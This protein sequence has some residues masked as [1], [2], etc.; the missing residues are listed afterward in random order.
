MKP[1]PALSVIVPVYNQASSIVENVR[2]IRRHVAG[3]LMEPVEFIVV[4]DGSIDRTAERILATRSEEIRVIHYDRNLGKGYAVKVGLL[5]GRADLIGFLDADLDVDPAALPSFVEDIRARGL[6]AAIGSKRHPGSEVDYPLRRRV[7][8]WLYQQLVRVLFQL[9]VTDTQ[10]GMKIFR[11][12]LVD[13][14]VPHLLVKRYAFDLE[15]LAVARDFGFRRIAE[16]PVRLRYRFSGSGVRPLAIAQAL[17]D[18]AAVFYRVKLL[19]YYRRRRALIGDRRLDAQLTCTVIICGDG[20]ND[21]LHATRA[22]LAHL[23]PAPAAVIERLI[24]SDS[25]IGDVTVQRL[26]ALQET[27]G[28]LVVFLRPGA[29][30]AAN[31]LGALLP[32]FANADVVAVGGPIL[33]ATAG[34]LRVMAAAAVYESR[35]AAGPVAKRHVPGNLR[36]ARDQPLDNLVVR[37]HVAVASGAFADAAELGNDANVSHR[38]SEHGKVLFTPDAP[39]TMHMPPLF[40]PLLRTLYAHARARGAGVHEGHPLP[41][42]TAAA[43]A[44]ALAGLL[45]PLVLLLPKKPQRALAG[46]IALYGL[47]L[48]YASAHAA[49]RH[50]SGRVGLSLVL[51]APAGH[52]VYGLGVLRGLLEPALT[53][54]SLCA[55]ASGAAQAHGSCRPRRRPA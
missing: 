20:D 43:G 7:Y 4:S 27:E 44:G 32:Y 29:V 31:W 19:R 13:A 11:R 2:E 8:S 38:L 5:A 22:A 14:V 12:E 42:S 34:G 45:L 53:A 30:P 15:L 18:T 26:L 41:L 17:I 49:L 48:A 50:R 54:S 10:V 47:S 3:S 46:L 52:L 39:V 16:E 55:R 23:E 6:D 37:R 35:F 1:P 9:D 33:P 28:D 25:S 24:G 21:A 51:T 40:T 36:E